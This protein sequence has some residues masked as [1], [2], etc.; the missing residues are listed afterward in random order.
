MLADHLTEL[1]VVQSNF[2]RPNKKR[3]NHSKVDSQIGLAN[4]WGV[5]LGSLQGVGVVDLTR[6]AQN[7]DPAEVISFPRPD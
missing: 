3:R 7:T 6:L 4:S 2:W 5:R 1:L